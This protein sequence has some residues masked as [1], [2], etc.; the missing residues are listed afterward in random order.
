MTRYKIMENYFRNELEKKGQ[1]MLFPPDCDDEKKPTYLQ[2]ITVSREDFERHNIRN[3][4]KSERLEKVSELECHNKKIYWKRVSAER[5]SYEYGDC[6][7]SDGG[8]GVVIFDWYVGVFDIPFE[9]CIDQGRIVYLMME[10][11]ENNYKPVIFRNG[12]WE[13]EPT[14]KVMERIVDYLISRFG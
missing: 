5:T 11:L 2:A 6:E 8:G 4:S 9:E 14:N 7:I 13:Y 10:D 1:V 3:L 12:K